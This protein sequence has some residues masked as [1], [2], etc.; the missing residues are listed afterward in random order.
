MCR[1]PEIA[2]QR[3]EL[4]NAQS[5]GCATP[6]ARTSFMDP[7]DAECLAKGFNFF[8]D[9]DGSLISLEIAESKL[10]ILEII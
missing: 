9:A 6:E 8:S 10:K 4:A 1:D 2:A 7:S 3:Q 5:R